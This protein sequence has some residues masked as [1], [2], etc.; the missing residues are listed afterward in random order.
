MPLYCLIGRDSLQGL[1]L[2]KQHRDA[3]LRNLDPV[4]AEG[5]VRYA[6]PLLDDGGDPCG[7]VI[8]FEAADLAS[9]R[10]LAHS[11]PYVTQGVFGS[12][13]VF[14]TRQVRPRPS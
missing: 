12:W 8:L 6:G 5:R 13:E 14:E 4:V 3:H 10:E 11:D 2:R 1:E 9:A 7:S